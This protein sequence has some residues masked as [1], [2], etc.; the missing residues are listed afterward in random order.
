[1]GEDARTS[2]GDAVLHR[3]TIVGDELQ[4]SMIRSLLES[5]GVR[6]VLRRPTG[7]QLDWG[8]IN[9]GGAGAREVLV[10]PADVELARALL[11]EPVE[12]SAS[13]AGVR[14]A[15][16]LKRRARFLHAVFVGVVVL[17]FGIPL[18]VALLVGIADVLTR[19]A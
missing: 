5:H 16:P 2:R 9:I 10:A 19:I 17:L 18:L 15:A 13:A 4:A 1:M 7:G 8:V 12:P 3:I 11:A 6:C 14:A